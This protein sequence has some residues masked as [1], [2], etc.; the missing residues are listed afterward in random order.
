MRT[1]IHISDIHFGRIDRSI[2]DSILKVFGEIKPDL[3]IIS[4]DVTQRAK[5]S[6]F[7]SAI[8]FINKLKELGI[9]S[10]V[11]PGN[12]DIEPFIK[13]LQR[14][15][16][17]Y[18]NYKKY[19]SPRIETFYADGELAVASL[20]TVRPSNI[21]DGHIE[22]AEIKRVQKWFTDFGPEIT[23][24]V[25][26]HHPLDLPSEKHKRKLA[27]YAHVGVDLLSTSN[28][29]LY[30]SGHLHRSSVVTTEERYNKLKYCAIAV[31]AGTVSSR[32]RGEVPSF[33]VLHIDRPAISLETYLFDPEAQVF[34]QNI[35]NNF[36]INQNLWRR[37]I[38]STKK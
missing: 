12:H 11:I 5:A 14:A 2:V 15:F 22:E 19:I 8:E 6:Q 33:N 16:D 3:I 36:E 31:S 37:S 28:I 24:I 10:F 1:I 32:Q 9:N 30:L 34:V 25:V 26:S 20:N 35:I 27:K 21:K 29:D 38:P 17:P 7:K 4:G 18:R 13:P 23:K